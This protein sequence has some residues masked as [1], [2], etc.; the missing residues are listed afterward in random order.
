VLPLL[1]FSVRSKV[2]KEKAQRRAP[3]ECTVRN[4]VAKDVN[5]PDRAML[6]AWIVL[7]I[8]IVQPQWAYRIYLRDVFTGFCPMEM[9]RVAGEND[10]AA[11]REP[12]KLVS[13]KRLAATNIEHSGHHG[14]NSVFLMAVRGHNDAKRHFDAYHVRGV[15]DDAS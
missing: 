10:D 8:N 2:V 3:D 9:C 4:V 14:V 13:F 1:R 6:A 11:R 5:K 7:W 15:D 12:G